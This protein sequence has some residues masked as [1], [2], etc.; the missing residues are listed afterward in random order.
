MFFLA[1]LLGSQNEQVVTINYFI[2]S[3]EFRLPVLLAS[4]F[5]AGFAISWIF[6]LYQLAKMKLALRSANKKL[7]AAETTALKEI[8]A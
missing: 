1:L 7:E 3:G 5:L 8:D 6:T 4:V 2:A